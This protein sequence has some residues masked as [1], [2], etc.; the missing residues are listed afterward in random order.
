MKFLFLFIF[1]Y[2]FFNKV[3]IFKD[4]MTHANHSQNVLL[5]PLKE[6]M[7]ESRIYMTMVKIFTNTSKA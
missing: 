7:D 4:V 3:V 2:N 6:E 1:F 5:L